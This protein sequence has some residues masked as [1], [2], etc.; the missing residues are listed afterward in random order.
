MLLF[1]R[2][3]SIHLSF[4]DKESDFIAWGT[5]ELGRFLVTGI[6][7][8]YP[9]GINFSFVNEI[10]VQQ[11]VTTRKEGVDLLVKQRFAQQL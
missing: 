5:F 7:N 11:L 9:L 8:F 2:F 1:Y 6:G 4:V 10:I 3:N